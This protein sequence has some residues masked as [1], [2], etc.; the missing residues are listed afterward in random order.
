[1]QRQYDQD[2]PSQFYSG[3]VAELYEPLAAETARADEY[4]SFLDQ[5]GP[6]ALELACGSGL[7]LV[8]LLE[9]GYEVDGLDASSDMLD[10]CRARAA[11]R[12]LAPT[13]YLADMQSFQLPRRY[14]SVFLAGASFTLL[15]TD[16]DA[17]NT[18]ERIY[19]HLESGGH[20]LIPLE[21]EDTQAIR[22]HLGR[23]REVVDPSG[24]RLRVAMLA[25]DVSADGRNLYH[26]LRYERIPMAGEPIAVERTWERRWWTQEQFRE[27]VLAAGF[28]ELAFLAPTGGPAKSD[29]S[30]FVALARRA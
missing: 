21:I 6:P 22:R 24:D 25:L 29:A 20:A 17:A 27:L 11:E 30:V 28:N 14:R 9:R 13:L 5:S 3:L 16:K 8:E 15:T 26:R 7:P 10:R 12:G 19:G 18:L 2:P 23:Y 1:M 4:I